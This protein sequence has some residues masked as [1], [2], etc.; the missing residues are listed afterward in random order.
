MSLSSTSAIGAPVIGTSSRPHGLDA[1]P[2]P[3]LLMI[4]PLWNTALLMKSD[5]AL[6]KAAPRLIALVSHDPSRM[7]TA[8]ASTWAPPAT[9]KKAQPE[10]LKTAPPVTC[11]LPLM[12][13]KPELKLVS[14]QTPLTV[15]FRYE[16]D[17]R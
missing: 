8:P 12:S 15:T 14:V 17:A 16:P 6:S 1:L 11:R 2:P 3:P 9:L 4:P 13:T 10:A 5:V 7:K